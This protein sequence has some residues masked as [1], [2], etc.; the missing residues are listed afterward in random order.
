MTKQPRPSLYSYP[1]YHKSEHTG[2]YTT[3][4]FWCMYRAILPLTKISAQRPRQCLTNLSSLTAGHHP[5]I[6]TKDRYAGWQ[7]GTAQQPQRTAPIG[8]YGI[9]ELL[10]RTPAGSPFHAKH[11]VCLTLVFIVHCHPILTPRIDGN[12][13]D[14]HTLAALALAELHEGNCR[15]FHIRPYP[16]RLIG[17][18]RETA[19]SFPLWK[20]L[21]ET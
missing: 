12:L 3:T 16:G 17:S 1:A 7:H 2:Q 13:D 8:T 14:D 21:S 10:E 9:T 6:A 4:V 20:R 11:A 18:V 15:C 19:S 5:A